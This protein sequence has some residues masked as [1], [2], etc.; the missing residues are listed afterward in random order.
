MMVATIAYV[1]RLDDT[2]AHKATAFLYCFLALAATTRLA[3][4]VRRRTP[5]PTLAMMTVGLIL[6]VMGGLDRVDVLSASNYDS[7][8]PVGIAR[9][10]TVVALGIGIA[11]VARFGA[12]LVQ[13]IRD[14]RGTL[15]STPIRRAQLETTTT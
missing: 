12:F 3:I 15:S 10:A 1:A 6:T 4:H 9:I 7:T 8:L 13:V 5:D 14:P 11:L 2:Q